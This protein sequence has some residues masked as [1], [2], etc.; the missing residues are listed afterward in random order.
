MGAFGGPEIIN[1][2]LIVHFAA[3]N[4]K[5]YP[6]SGNT[7]YN[8]VGNNDG[9]ATTITTI[10]SSP[11][12]VIDYNAGSTTAITCNFTPFNKYSW[13]VSYAMRGTATPIG[14]YRSI[15]NV[16]TPSVLFFNADTRETTGPY[17]LHYIKD[18][19]ISSWNT[20]Q[21]IATGEYT[22]FEWNIIDCVFRTAGVGSPQPAEYESWVNGQSVGTVTINKNISPYGDIDELVLNSSGSNTVE[23]QSFKLYNRSLSDAEVKQNYYAL[24]GRIK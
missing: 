9:T 8:L 14:N 5:S 1:D 10:E 6:G 11:G 21:V 18:Y 7:I 24:R 4:L 22:K 19:Y 12:T 17:I 16:L 23:L 13:S 20:Q 3:D 2:G 15:W